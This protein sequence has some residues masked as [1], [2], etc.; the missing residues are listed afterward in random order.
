MLGDLQAEIR[1]LEREVSAQRTTC[2]NADNQRQF[3]NHMRTCHKWGRIRHEEAEESGNRR[4]CW[5]PIA[6]R[7]KII[8]R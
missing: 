4:R 5:L 2:G 3:R 8:W 7:I 6:K 1:G